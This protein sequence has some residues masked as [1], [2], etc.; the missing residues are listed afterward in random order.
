MS[1]GETEKKTETIKTKKEGDGEV[2]ALSEQNFNTF[3]N[4]GKFHQV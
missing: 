2:S 4:S 3:S 1:Q